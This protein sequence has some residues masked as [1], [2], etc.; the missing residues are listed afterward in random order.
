M[1]GRDD[2]L[3]LELQRLFADERLDVRPIAGAQEAIVAGARRRRRRRTAAAGGGGALAVVAFVVGGMLLAGGRPPEQRHDHHVAAPAGTERVTTTRAGSPAPRSESETV[4]SS[5]VR[6]TSAAPRSSTG[7]LSRPSAPPSVS[8]PT[9]K[10]G[11]IMSVAVLGPDGYK[12]LKLNMPYDK[13][14][15]T[16]MLAADSSAPAAESCTSYRLAEGADAIRAVV[17]SGARGVV[18]FNAG[19]AQTAEG[20]AAGSPVRDLESAYAELAPEPSGGYSAPAGSGARYYFGT[21]DDTVTQVRL[22]NTETGC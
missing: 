22:A 8:V 4:R 15:G 7:S 21:A 17:I 16:G 3:D 18:A 9:S 10:Q 11:Q 19:S 6:R 1:T 13:A 2:E 20:I 12:A 14:A 5:P